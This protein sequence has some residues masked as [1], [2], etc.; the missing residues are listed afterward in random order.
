M[1]AKGKTESTS[2][3]SQGKA[4]AKKTSGSLSATF[5][6][7]TV[8]VRA[9]SATEIKRNIKAGQTALARAKPALAKK[10]V[11]LASPKKAPI[12]Y[13]DESAAGLI[14]RDIDGQVT[15]GRVVNGVFKALTK[16]GSQPNR[17][18]PKSAKA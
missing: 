10:G 15:K 4:S 16:I 1:K 6:S 11:T 7:V 17:T 8:V 5:G 2:L 14:V 12:Y 13:V 9:P 3:V 18:K